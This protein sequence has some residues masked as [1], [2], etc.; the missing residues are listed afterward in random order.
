MRK[1][2]AIAHEREIRES[3]QR[4]ADSFADW[5]AGKLRTWD[6]K[7]RLRRFAEGPSRLLLV[8][9]RQHPLGRNFAEHAEHLNLICLALFC[10]GNIDSARGLH[11]FYCSDQASR[12]TIR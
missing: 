7:D 5:Q 10:L 8:R 4:L 6:L 3:L 9:H 11:L 1:L 2:A 12:A